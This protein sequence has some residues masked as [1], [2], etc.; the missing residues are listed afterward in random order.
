MWARGRLVGLLHRSVPLLELVLHGGW[1]LSE[2]RVSDFTVVPGAV[3]L[4][5]G[6]VVP[7]SIRGRH[8][9]VPRRI[10]AS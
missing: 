6:W 8:Q 10:R 2:Y 1:C 4:V 9:R 7:L 3:C 5:F